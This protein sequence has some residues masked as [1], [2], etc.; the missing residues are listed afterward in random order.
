MNRLLRSARRPLPAALAAAVF[1]YGCA[2]SAPPA[3]D[4]TPRPAAEAV[5][6]EVPDLDL[7][8]LL[9]LLV[10]R[11]AFDPLTVERALRGG[12]ALREELAVA[13]G[14]IP[15]P[16][17]RAALERLLLDE[18]V[19]VRRA[20]AFGLGELEDA[21]AVPALIGALHDAD[22][23]TAI[24]AV[25]ALGKLGASVIEVAEALIGLP[26]EERWGRLLPHLFRFKE[27]ARVALAERGL[28]QGDRMLHARAAYALAREPLPAALPALRRLLADPD[29]EVRAWAARGLGLAGEGADLELLR[30]LL[31]PAGVWTRARPSRPCAPPRS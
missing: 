2:T 24:L 23:E 14:R 11:Q 7:R 26:D 10:D 30:P 16:Q 4:R 25:E 17:G 5:A 22:R 9:L 29:P 6:L 27:E 31:D 13:L 3:P 19:A 18:E 12:P 1:A 28:E 20:A 21:A 8:A 15:D